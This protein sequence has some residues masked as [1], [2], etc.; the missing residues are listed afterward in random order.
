MTDIPWDKLGIPD[1]M[2]AAVEPGAPAATRLAAAKGALGASGE[3]L[4]G[5]LYVLACGADA[6]VRSA[7]IATL[8]GLPNLAGT[9]GQKTHPK[10]L[11]FVATT[12]PE[13]AL[14]ERISVIRNANDRTA[15]LIARRA[16]RKLCELLCENHER[17]LI[18][19]DVIVALHQNPA[20][21]DHALERAISFL[22]MH[23]SLPALPPSR[24]TAGAPA[25][26]PPPPAPPPAAPAAFDL[27]AE[28]E[29]ALTG[30]PS[31]HLQQQ[32]KL[33]MFDVDKLGAGGL[34][35]FS[36]D[37]RDDD[38]FS[39]DLID[40]DAATDDPEGKSSIEK[41][42]A[43][44]SV[45]K[46]LKLAFLGNKTVRSLLIRDRNKM[47]AVAVVKGGRCT[48]AEVLTYAGNRNLPGEVLREIAANKE[49]MRKYPLKVALANNP[50]CPPAIAVSLVSQLQGKDLASLARNRNVSN[51]VFSL[52]GKLAKQKS[53]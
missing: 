37:F 31:P 28:I 33:T 14:D 52:A 50:K 20:C 34:E 53:L 11:E 39:L 38:V 27:E 17:L 22:R 48:D 7:A 4:V 18:T 6:E 3:A 49:W 26:P 35:G 42:I 10:V 13:P 12:R 5:M 29:A 36:F 16:D 25:T 15:T 41:K 19:P 46:K 47:V 40:E 2:R 23:E 32:S 8:Q 1:A 51:V 44:M 30:K 9:L 43:T 45:G 24:P 21:G